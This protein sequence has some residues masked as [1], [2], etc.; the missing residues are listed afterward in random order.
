LNVL[1][2][3]HT[4]IWFYSND[5]A[6]SAAASALIQDPA[7]TVLVSPASYWEMAIK[8]STGKLVLAEPFLDFIQHA[9]ADNGFIILPIEPRHCD[10]VIGLPYHHRDPFDRILIAQA[11]AD[12]IAIVG[13]D[14]V[15]DSYPIRRLW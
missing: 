4:L 6:L 10:A 5:A 2:D 8:M 3:T 9:V 15:F 11:I 1:L 12:S 14:G 7:N 13:A